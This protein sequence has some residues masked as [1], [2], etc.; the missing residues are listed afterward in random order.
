M[1]AALPTWRTG[2]DCAS[3]TCSSS[4]SGVGPTVTGCR[5]SS[6]APTY[7]E[8][9]PV[10]VEGVE[11]LL[12][13]GG[14][15][16]NNPTASAYAEMVRLMR[17]D[18]GPPDDVR[19]ISLGTGEPGDEKRYERAQSWNRLQWI[20]PLLD[21]MFDG[22]A[23]IVDYQMTYMV[24]NNYIRLQEPLQSADEDMDNASPRNINRLRADGNRVVDRNSDKLDVIVGWLAERYPV[25]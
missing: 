8:P 18:G 13:D 1:S 4:S 24:G 17:E 2:S 20:G 6:S 12:V 3:P 5:A 19:V 7:F 22:M 21:A 25:D 16:V 9:L 23:D 10:T 14:V 11:T 15:C